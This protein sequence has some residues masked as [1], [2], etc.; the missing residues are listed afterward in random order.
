MYNNDKSMFAGPVMREKP[1][2]GGPMPRFEMPGNK[3]KSG[4]KAKKMDMK[5]QAVAKYLG[6]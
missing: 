2:T 3:S 4:D 6:K 5:K 1:R